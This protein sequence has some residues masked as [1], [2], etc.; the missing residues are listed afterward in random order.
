[1]SDILVHTVPAMGT[2]V[3]LQVVGHGA[4]ETERAERAEIGRAHV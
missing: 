4:T 3:T 1:M 2:V